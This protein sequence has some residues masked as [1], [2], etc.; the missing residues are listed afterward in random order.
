MLWW[1]KDLETGID[2]IDSQHKSI[3]DK[4]GE[5]FNLGNN[6][7]FEDIEKTFVFLM[8]YANNH[9]YEEEVLMM[10]SS[11]EDFIEHRKEHNYFIEEIY[12]IY[13]SLS[14]GQVSEESLNDLKALIIDWL[15]NHI[16]GDDRRYIET[17]R[18][19]L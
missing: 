15:V 2:I 13:Q 6:S 4:A 12:R 10:E 1:T 18:E 14:S 16:N 9:F 5:I 8:S 11:Y 7:S 3:F 17:I 19:G